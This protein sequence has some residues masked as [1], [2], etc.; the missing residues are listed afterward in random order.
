MKSKSIARK[1]QLLDIVGLY[2]C[3]SRPSQQLGGKYS[4]Q[5]LLPAEH[6]QLPDLHRQF[7]GCA[8]QAFGRTEGVRYTLKKETDPTRLERQPIYKGAEFLNAK[9]KYTPRVL[10]PQKQE[11]TRA[12]F[13]LY[14]YPG[15]RFH[16]ELVIFSYEFGKRRDL[17]QGI[18]AR[19][20]SVMLLGGGQRLPELADH[21]G[22]FQGVAPV[23]LDQV[24]G[25]AA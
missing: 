25:G 17:T 23:E 9:T 21:A 4:I 20:A 2:P 7:E 11:A 5:V 6:P 14:E 24:Q 10:N 8:L 18:G 13:S 22:G 3:L 12:D 15:A 1:I 16:V 19:L